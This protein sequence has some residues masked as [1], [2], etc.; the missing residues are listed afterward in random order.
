MATRHVQLHLN[1]S[2]NGITFGKLE[3]DD[4]ITAKHAKM[5]FLSVL[6]LYKSL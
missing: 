1:V 6:D 4:V 2:G 5:A 3:N